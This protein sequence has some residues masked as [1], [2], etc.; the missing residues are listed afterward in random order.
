L[1]WRVPF[2]IS[3]LFSAKRNCTSWMF[4][5]GTYPCL[6]ECSDVAHIRVLLNVRMWHI[7]VSCWMLGCGTYPCLAKCSDVAHIRVLLNVRM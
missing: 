5:F 2:E 7:S 4:G 3:G 1:K 6:A